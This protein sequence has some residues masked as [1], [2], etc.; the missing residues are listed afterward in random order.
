MNAHA[1]KGV[2]TTT[3]AIALTLILSAANSMAKFLV[4][5]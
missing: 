5:A 3:G 4:R 1:P 2:S